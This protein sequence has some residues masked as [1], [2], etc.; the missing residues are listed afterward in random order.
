MKFGTVIGDSLN[1][2]HNK[3]G[4]SNSIPLAPPTVQSHVFADNFWTVSPKIKKFLLD[5]GRHA[6]STDIKFWPISAIL[7]YVLKKG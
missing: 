3:F 4:V 1:C 7:N 5:S 2:Q 6:E